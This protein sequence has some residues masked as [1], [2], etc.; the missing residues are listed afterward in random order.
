MIK[1]LADSEKI[2]FIVYHDLNL[3]L[4]TCDEVLI[5]EQ[6]CAENRYSLN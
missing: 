2:I 4:N 6:G 1:K 5:V 3:L